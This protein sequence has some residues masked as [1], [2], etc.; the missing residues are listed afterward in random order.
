[1]HAWL[2]LGKV[3]TLLYVDI[4]LKLLQIGMEMGSKSY[5]LIDRMYSLSILFSMCSFKRPSN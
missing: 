4:K 5:N 1:M 2:I 3:L